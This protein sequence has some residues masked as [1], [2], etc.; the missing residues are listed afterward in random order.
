MIPAYMSLAADALT[1]AADDC[2]V[3]DARVLSGFLMAG[4]STGS[5]ASAWR[6]R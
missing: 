1:A 4:L 2:M 5:A 6:V 3:Q